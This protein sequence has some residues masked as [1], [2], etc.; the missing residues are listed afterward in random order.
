M[1]FRGVTIKIAKDVLERLLVVSM[2]S[3]VLVG[4][5]IP[6]GEGPELQGPENNAPKSDQGKKSQQEKNKTQVLKGCEKCPGR[7]TPDPKEAGKGQCV[8]CLKDT[9]CQSVSHPTNRC[10]EHRT[11]VCGSDKD[12]SGGE[13]CREPKECKNC[14]PKCVRKEDLDKGEGKCDEACAAKRAKAKFEGVRITQIEGLGSLEA[15]QSGSTSLP[16]KAVLAQKRFQN[17]WT[18]HG[19]KLDKIN[20][21]QLVSVNDPKQIFEL[22][23]DTLRRENMRTITLPKTLIAGLFFLYTIAGVHKISLAQVF[24]LQGEGCKIVKDAATDAVTI[25][26][27]NTSQT[28]NL[29]QGPQGPAGQQGPKGDKGDKGMKGD[30]GVKG[31]KGATGAVGAQGTKG[32]KGV[33]GDR[34]DAGKDGAKGAKGD[35]GDKGDAGPGF[36]TATRAFVS[37][38]KSFVSVDAKNKNIRITG[39]NLQIVSGSGTSGGKVNGTGNLIIGYNENSGKKAQSGSHNLVIGNEHG[40][41]SHSGIVTGFNSE[42]KAPYAAILS[43]RNNIVS[44]SNSGI[45]GA[46]YSLASGMTAAVCGGYANRATELRSTAVGGVFGKAVG[47]SSTVLGGYS[48]QASGLYSTVTGGYRNSTSIQYGN[49]LVAK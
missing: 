48:N 10:S 31:D 13:V 33:K 36:D 19:Q 44:G 8:Q 21:L 41:S 47:R 46:S 3:L 32:D 22:N 45:F 5:G 23:L 28:L 1:F 40:Y 39:A 43:G 35:K 49:T 11:C 6:P 26:C 4:C 15:I 24:V 34:G 29:P 12:C 38:L 25:Q 30:K 2:L 16:K 20:R 14:L 7:C 37:N 18:L 17:K 27:G 9:H 42:L